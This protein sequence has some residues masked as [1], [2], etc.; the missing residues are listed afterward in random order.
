VQCAPPF[1]NPDPPTLYFTAT[2]NPGAK[3]NSG[4]CPITVSGLTNGVA[5]TFTVTA[6]NAVGTGPP[7]PPSNSVTP[8][9]GQP[10]APTSVLAAAGDGQAIVTYIPPAFDGGSPI[11]TYTATSS[12]GGFTASVSVPGAAITV[13]GL[14]NGVAYTFT[15]TATNAAGTG[16]PSAPSN[17]VTPVAPTPGL[18]TAPLAAWATAGNGQ[19]TVQCGPPFPNPEPPT[20]FFTATSNPGG[21]S[22]SAPNCAAIIVMGLTNG[23]AYTFT[24]TAT[25]AVG[26]GPP[27]PPT[28]SVTPYALTVPGPPTAVSATAGQAQ[29]RVSFSPPSSDGGS[30]IT[31]YTA[32]SSPG[33][34]TASGASSPLTV[35]GLANGTAYTFTVTATNSIGTG[36]SSSAS[37]SVTPE[38]TG[39][40]R[41][42]NISTRL[43]VLTGNDVMIGGFVIGGSSSKT[44]A[45]VATGPSLAQFALPNPLQNPILT[46]VRS[47]DQAVMA[48]N[49]NW[50]TTPNQ[51]QLVAAGLAPSNVLD[52]AILISLA[53]GAYTA[54]VQGVQ[55]GTGV[56]LIGIYEVDTPQAPLTNISTRGRV[57]TGNDVMIGGFVVDGSAP[58]TVA[59]VATGPSLADFGI[60]SPLANPAIMLVRSSDQVVL[61]TN[62][63]WQDDSDQALLQSAGFAPSS[64]LESG[65]YRTLPPG[66][67][68]VIVTGVG[69]TTGVAVIGIYKVN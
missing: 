56:A 20:L 3:S 30:A 5:Y 69:N 24:V 6:T 57:L 9:G 48:T 28:A 38:G 41:L 52:A 2:S 31:S 65:L 51:G 39:P 4:F 54:I 15:V 63:N 18:P 27:S 37:N 7:S 66:A 33:G 60:A 21:Y 23:T 34:V 67:Y 55:G 43:Q 50:Q 11:T 1:P 68:T 46:L 42:A 19:A 32:T 45:I 64:V 40:P 26:T 47:S 44:V 22:A 62:D 12:P 29:A 13:T 17:S 16:P 10:G 49:D 14:T 35:T 36:P 61:A 58:Q 25:N 8:S 53:P 59:I